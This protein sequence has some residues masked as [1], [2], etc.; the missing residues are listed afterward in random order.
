MSIFTTTGPA[1]ASSLRKCTKSPAVRRARPKSTFQVAVAL[2]R[3]LSLEF[4]ARR[5][6]HAAVAH[7]RLCAPAAYQKR[8]APASLHSLSL[9]H[10]YREAI[11]ND[12]CNRVE[13]LGYQSQVL[14]IRSEISVRN[15]HHEADL[16]RRL[17]HNKFA[18][19]QNV[20]GRCIGE[21]H[22]IEHRTKRRFAN[23]RAGLPNGRE[24]N[25]EKLRVFDVVNPR[26]LNVSRHIDSE[27][28]QSNASTG[29]R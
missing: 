28:I 15:A 12:G 20:S 9:S 17:T 3:H 8:E 10:D 16:L 26:D 11:V 18:V 6:L 19:Q 13:K 23:C 22:A 29:P 4:T 25:T 1:W 24:G 14:T 21:C 27:L 7:I 2:L 5:T